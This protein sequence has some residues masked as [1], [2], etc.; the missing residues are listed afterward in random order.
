LVLGAPFA[1][2]ESVI[3][4]AE[5]SCLVAE[6]PN[7]VNSM[8]EIGLEEA[9]AQ[10]ERTLPW[11]RPG[12]LVGLDGSHDSLEAL[13]FALD[14]AP[15]LDLPVHALVVWDPVSKLKDDYMS[16]DVLSRDQ[17]D[18]KKVIAATRRTIFPDG[19]P[20]W[21]T[22][23]A[24]RGHPAFVL[25]ANSAHAAMLVLGRRGHGG[26]L[27]LLLGSVSAVCVPHALCPVV[28]VPGHGM[29]RSTGARGA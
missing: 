22:F 11:E 23:G 26:F 21:F 29:S 25:L 10:A 12:I 20:S 24:Q 1:R 14:L 27:G 15:K 9:A 8:N 7:E 2:W 3:A 5:P 18:A 13:R 4:A 19:E 17:E 28:V 16:N 6:Q